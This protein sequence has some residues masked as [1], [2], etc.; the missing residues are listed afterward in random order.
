VIIKSEGIVEFTAGNSI[1]LSAGFVAEEGCDFSAG[2]G[3]VP[4]QQYTPVEVVYAYNNLNR[5]IS[6]GK[7]DDIDFY[8]VYE[9][10]PNGSL[11]GEELNNLYQSIDYSYNSPGWLKGIDNDLFAEDITYNYPDGTGYFSGKIAKSEFSFD[12][13][14]SIPTTY[15]YSYEYDNIGRL[16]NADHCSSTPFDLSNITYDANGNIL[17]LTKGTQ[18]LTYNYVPNTN[19]IS[20][21]TGLG[22]YTYDDVGNITSSSEKELNNLDYDPFT[23]LTTEVTKDDGQELMFNYG[24]ANQRVLKTSIDTQENL[25]RT[26]YLRGIMDYPLMELKDGELDRIYIYGLTGLIAAMDIEENCYFMLKDHLGSIRS[27]INSNNEVVS[28]YCYDPFGEIIESEVS[29]DV[30]YQYTGQEFDWETGLHNYRARM[31]DSSLR[32]F[33]AVDPLH[34]FASPYCYVGNNP[35]SFVDPD[36]RLGLPPPPPPPV[37]N[38]PEFMFYYLDNDIVPA[39]MW[40]GVVDGHY[41][42]IYQDTSVGAKWARALMYAIETG[43]IQFVKDYFAK[44][45]DMI[46]EKY[47]LPLIGENFLNDEGSIASCYDFVGLFFEKT[48]DGLMSGF[49]IFEK[50]HAAIM[51]F[52]GNG[53]D[54]FVSK[55][56][57]APLS[58]NTGNELRTGSFLPS[59][60]IFNGM[61]FTGYGDYSYVPWSW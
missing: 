52:S 41:G 37:S 51:I 60:L 9:Y 42:V 30:K 61:E 53:I 59:G 12:K 13:P 11:K 54:I 29:F 32:R 38:E 21:I 24:A 31:Y 46:A 5:L 56:Y 23:Y 39:S 34:Q 7:P 35:V 33:Y 26:L 22:T 3:D 8:A 28:Y 48:N 36:G 57:E 58:V 20:S 19:K 2:I 43:N 55:N 14:G 4:P 18:N 45:Y 27:V 40:E 50:G 17:S 49:Y 44:Q 25:T 6:I 15:D 10:N 1:T 47:G 16:I